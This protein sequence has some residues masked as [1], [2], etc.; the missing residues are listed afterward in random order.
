MALRLIQ[1]FR[2]ISLPSSSSCSVGDAFSH[3]SLVFA[4]GFYAFLKEA[5]NQIP[6]PSYCFLPFSSMIRD[7]H[8]YCLVSL[9][10]YFWEITLLGFC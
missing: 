5:I 8:L 4:C 2:N 6:A 10:G 3:Y 7:H 9:M 1:L